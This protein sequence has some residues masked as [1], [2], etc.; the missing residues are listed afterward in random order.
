VG[1]AASYNIKILPQG[2]VVRGSGGLKPPQYTIGIAPVKNGLRIDC[3][4]SL[5][6]TKAPSL[7]VFG[8]RGERL[9][10][11]GSIPAGRSLWRPGSGSLSCGIYIVR[12]TWPDGGSELKT[13]LFAR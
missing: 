4:P 10:F 3:R 8:P 6:N 13:V 11:C 2:T 5:S 1:T 9:G 7:T 12:I